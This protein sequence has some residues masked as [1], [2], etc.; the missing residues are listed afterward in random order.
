MD[1]LEAQ[2]VLLDP[3]KHNVPIK[4]ISPCFLRLKARAKDKE[5]EEC[6]LSEIRWIISPAQLNP[7]L[8]QLYTNTVSKEDLFIFKSE[9]PYCIEFDLYE[10]YF[11]NHLCQEDWGYLAVETPY[12]G[13][14]VLTRSG[15]GLLNQEIQTSYSPRFLGKKLPRR[16]LSCRLTMDRWVE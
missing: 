2:N 6:D 5:M 13:L 9:K 15:Q 4:L 11:Q 1:Q 14:R 3:Y 10:G 7:H 8:K 12:K 16:M